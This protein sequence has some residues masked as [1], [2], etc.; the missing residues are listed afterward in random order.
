MRSAGQNPRVASPGTTHRTTESGA[1]G[2]P[3]L[4]DIA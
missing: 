4:K 1:L 3:R 2:P